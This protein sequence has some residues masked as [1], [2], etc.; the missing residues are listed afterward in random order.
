MICCD[1]CEAWQHNSCMGL[2]EE[3]PEKK[4]Y[5]CE[6]CKPQDHKELLAAIKRGEKPW[7]MAKQRMQQAYAEELAAKKKGKKGGRKSN[8]RQ[9]ESQRTQSAEP[10]EPPASKKRKL[11]ESP[12]PE[13]ETK[14]SHRS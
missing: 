6:Q 12:A 3:W 9:V 2:P 11:E 1:R 10:E 14:V 13:V 4:K 7:E 5:F 8:A